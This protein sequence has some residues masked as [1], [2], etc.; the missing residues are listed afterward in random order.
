MAKS[1]DSTNQKVNRFGLFWPAV[2]PMITVH[3]HFIRQ[4]GFQKKST[5]EIA[6]AGMDY[7]MREAQS[8]LW[9]ND[10]WHPWRELTLKSF[11]ENRLISVCLLYT[12][13]SPRDS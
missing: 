4:G 5:G 10:D 12:S 13:P 2:T 11:C 8:L 7:H 3:L 1:I 9:P 6:G